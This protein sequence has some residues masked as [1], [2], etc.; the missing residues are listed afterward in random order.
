MGLVSTLHFLRLL[1]SSAS[2]ISGQAECVW[3][4][5]GKGFTPFSHRLSIMGFCDSVLLAQHPEKI[6]FRRELLTPV[7]MQWGESSRF[8]I[9]LEWIRTRPSSNSPHITTSC[10]VKVFSPFIILDRILYHHLN[11]HLSSVNVGGLL[12]GE[13]VDRAVSWTRQSQQHGQRPTSIIRLYYFV[14]PKEYWA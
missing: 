1:C 13:A 14:S 3:A 11:F 4:G 7:V 9:A 6:V 10:G 2:S 5:E 8:Y 12:V